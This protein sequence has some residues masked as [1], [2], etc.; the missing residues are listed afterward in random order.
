MDLNFI[1]ENLASRRESEQYRLGVRDFIRYATS[2]LSSSSGKIYCP[3]GKCVNN[4]LLSPDEVNLHLLSSGMMCNYSTWI[5]HGEQLEDTSVDEPM[6]TNPPLTHMQQ[7]VHDAYGQR[8]EESGFN[9]SPPVI[10][11]A[12]NGQSKDAEN[13]FNLLKDADQELWPGCEL[14]KLSFLVLLFHLKS[15]NKWSNKSISNLL[16]ILRLAIPNG[17]HLPKS[18]AEAKKVISKLGL[19]YIKIDACPKHCQ[20]YWKEKIGDDTCSTCGTSRWKRVREQLTSTGRKK[21]KGIP[22]NVLRYFPLK[23]RLK[24]LFMSK[25][26]ASYMR[27]HSEGRT[28][29]DKVLRHPADSNAWQDFDSRYPNFGAESRNVR[30]GLAS[31]GFNPFGM[32]SSTYS[33][34]PVVLVP[35]NLPPWM[36]LKASSLILSTLIPGPSSPGNKIDVYLQP[37][38]EELIELW[39]EGIETY[40]ASKDETFTLHAGLLWTINDFPGYGMLSGWGVHGEKACPCCNSQTDSKWLYNSH[41]FCYMGSRRLLEENHDFRYNKEAFNG[42]EEHEVAPTTPSGAEVL[43]QIED[44]QDFS[45]SKTWKKKSEFFKLPY[46]DSHLIRHNLDVMHIEKNV[47]DNVIGTLLNLE[48]KSKDNLKARRD[49]EV[50]GIRKEL[51]PQERGSRYYLPPAPYTMSRVEK[52]AFCKLLHELKVPNG[53][54]GNISRCVNLTQAKLHG[55]KSH[56]NHILMQQILPLHCEGAHTEVV[57]VLF[58]LCGYFRDLCGKVLH[59]DEIAR[60]EASIPQIMCHLEMIF[61]PSFFTIMVHLVVHLATEAKLAGPVRY[62]WMYFIERYLGKLKSYVFNKARPEGSIAEAHLAFEC[63][64]FCSHYIEGF[65]SKFPIASNFEG[66][67][68]ILEST[69]STHDNSIFVQAGK[70][71]GKPTTSKI[72][73][74]N[75]IQAHRYILFNSSEVTEFLKACGEKLKRRSRPR[76]L[77]L[78]EIE[79]IQHETFHDWFREHVIKLEASKGPECLNEERRM[80]AHGPLDVI[81]KYQGYNVNGFSFRAKR[82]DKCTQNS[83]VVVVAK[84]SSYASASDRRPVLGDVTYYG[85]IIEIIELKYLGGYSTIMFKCEWIDTTPGRGTK[86]DEYG[87]TLVNFSRLHSGETLTDEPYIFATQAEQ[88]F[89]IQDQVNEEWSV[90]LKMKPK[91]VNDI[92][93]DGL[94]EDEEIEPYHVSFLNLYSNTHENPSWVRL[95]VEGT[96]VDD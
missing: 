16:E 91:H 90:A 56:D 75:K 58:Q 85:R 46:W 55:L 95:G 44:I 33:C 67:A 87:F 86:Q 12:T 77:S 48:G 71:L 28:K 51:H 89:Y 34:W 42:S 79:R 11:M 37:L 50:M 29:E 39:D 70:P 65:D 31:D 94:S 53:Y 43:R 22:A 18:F 10:N 36:C 82:Y 68:E 88:V 4:K 92:G 6:V 69:S 59:L 8:N 61:P 30:L 45:G 19:D 66:C 78:K 49:L 2:D 20:L 24:R 81:T 25:K 1:K 26:T 13:F 62:R 72:S 52:H 3:C 96:L 41:K 21:K 17:E 47:C 35:Y 32:L 74:M 7:L 40:D 38:I 84:T 76:R 5:F 27:W 54:A 93:D 14:T 63:M 83:G 15:T 64:I 60:L 23:P 73:A 9:D 80:L 57:A